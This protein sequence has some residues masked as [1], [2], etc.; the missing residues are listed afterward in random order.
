M[1]TQVQSAPQ[2]QPLWLRELARDIHYAITDDG[3]APLQP[4]ENNQMREAIL[5]VLNAT[6][7]R[8]RLPLRDGYC[9]MPLKGTPEIFNAM[10]MSVG[11][12][13]AMG[14]VYYAALSAGAAPPQSD[15]VMPS[16]EAAQLIT[17]DERAVI[18]RLLALTFAAWSV[19]DGTCDDGGE[20]LKAPRDD[21]KKLSDELDALDEL[22]DDQPGYTMEAA[23]KARWALR[24]LIGGADSENKVR[25]ATLCALAE[26]TPVFS[27]RVL[28]I[29]CTV[30]WTELVQALRADGHD[31][32]DS[33]GPTV[34]AWM[35]TIV[36]DTFD[37]ARRGDGY[38][39]GIM[40]AQGALHDISSTHRDPSATAYAQALLNRLMA[41]YAATAE[42]PAAKASDIAPE[43]ERDMLAEAI[44]GAAVKSGIVRDDVSL[45]GPHLL[46]L[47]DDLANAAKSGVPELTDA[48]CVAI[49]QAVSRANLTRDMKSPERKRAI[50]RAAMNPGANDGN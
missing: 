2:Q 50:V 43:R 17:A 41:L 21:F 32:K 28:G 12:G 20:D 3:L 35:E 31:V 48:Q 49:Y 36:R 14:P 30:A 26:G 4:H 29:A 22:P 1:N 37:S 5:R 10:R 27:D 6:E 46:M 8:M 18:E 33:S 16:A 47:C 25:D 19:T 44:R 11:D 39:R 34:R 40:D 45:S 42:A 13:V 24:R 23:A 38:R 15:R 9:L 7:A